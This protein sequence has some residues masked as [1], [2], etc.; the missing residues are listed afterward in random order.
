MSTPPIRF[1]DKIRIFSLSNNKKKSGLADRQFYTNQLKWSS[2][3][4]VYWGLGHLKT[5]RLT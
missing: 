5:Y 3:F 2:T 4:S 1:I